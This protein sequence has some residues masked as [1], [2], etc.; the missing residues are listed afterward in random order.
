M[1]LLSRLERFTDP[2]PLGDPDPPPRY[3]PL[4]LPLRWTIVILNLGTLLKGTPSR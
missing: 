2:D 3:D 1:S 4:D